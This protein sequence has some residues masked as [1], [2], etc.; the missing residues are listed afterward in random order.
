MS[1][2]C[3]F[4]QAE[5]ERTTIIKEQRPPRASYHSPV[6]SAFD[7][8]LCLREKKA[9]PPKEGGDPGEVA[10]HKLTV[11]ALVALLPCTQLQ[12]VRSVLCVHKCTD[13]NRCVETPNHMKQR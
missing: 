1:S 6:A 4:A 3:Q 11:F 12:I 5:K 13:V 8:T 7:I 2:I 9:G 10:L